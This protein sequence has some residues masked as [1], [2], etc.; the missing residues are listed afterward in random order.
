MD[1]TS[2]CHSET[3]LYTES[4]LNENIKK[5][6]KI[7]SIFWELSLYSWII[8]IGF[9][10][11]EIIIFLYKKNE[12]EFVIWS[13]IVI[14]KSNKISKNYKEPFNIPIQMNNYLFIL[15]LIIIL[16]FSIFQFIY[17]LINSFFKNKN[18]YDS[19][20]GPFSKF[21][22]FPLFCYNAVFFIGL[23]P[24]F[25]NLD[26]ILITNLLVLDII[27]SIFGLLSLIFIYIQTKFKYEIFY[28]VLIIKKGTYSCLLA[29]MVYHIGYNITLF[30]YLLEADNSDIDK[31]GISFSVIIGL[32]N[33]LLG[34]CFK[35]ITILFMNIF[36][37]IGIVIEKKNKKNIL[38]VDIIIIVLFFSLAIF[39]IIRA[40]KNKKFN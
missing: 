23:F 11:S 39:L 34:L 18:I 9:G 24:T 19:M 5:R 30:E 27:I 36:I 13:F 15:L 10:F 2:I 29:L 16:I 7:G 38:I 26:K 31:I 12:E 20:M 37:Y 17:Y 32:L 35:D 14:N 1:T 25:C 6:P 22:F 8:F 40:V 3:V 4:I 28:K 21:H 33:L